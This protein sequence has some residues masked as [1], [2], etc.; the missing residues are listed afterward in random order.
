MRSSDVSRADSPDAIPGLVAEKGAY[1]LG[2]FTVLETVRAKI[3]NRWF[4]RPVPDCRRSRRPD[5]VVPRKSGTEV[6]A[7]SG[8]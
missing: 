4:P 8:R 6:E 5:R 2:V 7:W 1:S 3:R